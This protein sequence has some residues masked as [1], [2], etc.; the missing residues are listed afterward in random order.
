[1]NSAA[2]SSGLRDS[3]DTV[4]YD[5]HPF[6][7]SHP[8]RLATIGTIFGM[9]PKLDG[10]RVLEIGCASGGN[11]LP[12]AATLPH[13]NF[14]GIDFSP[15]QIERGNA[16]LQALAL[17]NAQL[18][19]MDLLEFDWSLGTFDYIIAHGVLSWVPRAVQDK[20]FEVCA[21][22]L[23]PGGIGYVS[24]NTLPGWSMRRTVRDAMRFHTRGVRDPRLR[25]QHARGVLEFLARHAPADDPGYAAMLRAENDD[26][27]AKAD[28]YIFHEHLEEV[29][30]AFY[31]HEVIE[32]AG[33]VGLK[34]L[35]EAAFRSMFAFDIASPGQQALLNLA[36]DLV[37]REQLLD[38]LRHRTFR[39]TL[40]VRDTTALE[41]KV[42]PVRIKTLHVASRA[43][44]TREGARADASRIYA[45]PDGCS[46]TIAGA[47]A[48][49]A[50]RI[51]ADAWPERVAFATLL[52]RSRA[53]LGAPTTPQDEP[54]LA[55]ALVGAYAAG[56]VELH[57]L[58]APFTLTPGDRP[59]AGAMQRL[60]AARS[61]Q[62]TTLRHDEL[63]VDPV[64]QQ[65][66]LLLD[67]A[68]TRDGIARSAWPAVAAD[69]A[70]AL[71]DQALPQLARQALLVA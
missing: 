71:L 25:V 8:D 47:L 22:Q 12:M 44:P 60:L 62:I 37:T 2:S 68:K 63:N 1:M 5:S 14:V 24:Y 21:R 15:V 43:R 40:L 49:A 11:L 52:E 28:Y 34:Y 23:A 30:E 33:A 17:S 31:F 66:L 36:P 10:A 48:Q 51:L 64:T 18:L 32:R 69:A 27:Q 61:R 56:T 9:S 55:T 20:L 3:Y 4:P 67:G 19:T 58:P 39:Q 42:S 59:Q 46:A 70:R 50:M 29:N 7:H 45:T 57:A 53:S 26:V 13:W 35:G 65:L 41:R 6:A 38:F 16:D 54:A